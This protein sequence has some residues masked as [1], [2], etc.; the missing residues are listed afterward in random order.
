MAITRNFS[1]LLCYLSVVH[2]ILILPKDERLSSRGKTLEKSTFN[3]IN[4]QIPSSFIDKL[5]KEHRHG[6][7]TVTS[8]HN[9]QRR[10]VSCALDNRELES[11][12]VCVCVCGRVRV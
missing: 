1:I 2:C 4:S 8:H 6:A 3:S 5:L 7:V 11:D 9:V 10:D 12:G